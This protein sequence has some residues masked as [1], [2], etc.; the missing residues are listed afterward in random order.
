MALFLPT[1]SCKKLTDVTLNMLRS[2]KA[3]AVF[4]DVD[5]TLAFH[6]SQEPFEGVVE[7]TQMVRQDGISII[8]MSN[9]LKSR[10]EPFAKKFDLPYVCF[11]Q[12]PFPLGLP[13]ARKKL[14]RKSPDKIV[15][16]GDQVYTDILGANLHGMQ[17]VLLEPAA[18]EG[19]AS[20]HFRRWLEKPVRRKLHRLAQKAKGDQAGQ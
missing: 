6:G 2:M 15:V 5:N 19:S 3:E 20:F 18:V 10:V 11:A 14:V 4:L 1:Y 13:Y 7:W 8:I 12:K 17:S 9:N 16:I